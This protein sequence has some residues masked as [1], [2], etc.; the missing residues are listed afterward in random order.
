MADSRQFLVPITVNRNLSAV[1]YG[2]LNTRKVPGASPGRHIAVY[3]QI[4]SDSKNS[5]R[6]SFEIEQTGKSSNGVSS[7][8]HKF[9]SRLISLESFMLAVRAKLYSNP[10][11]I[12][13]FRL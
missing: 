12:E 9:T 2:D 3:V 1:V 10:I 5:H 8:V 4:E 6:L 11:I 7:G 13:N